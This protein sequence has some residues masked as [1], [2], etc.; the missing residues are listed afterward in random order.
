LDPNLKL[1]DMRYFL[2]ILLLVF[3]AC[4]APQMPLPGTTGKAGELVIVMDDTNWESE[5]GD[6][7]FNVLSQHV[8]GLPQPEPMFNVVHIKS[9]AF[10]SIFKTHR[11][12]VYATIGKGHA[13]SIQL[14]TNVWAAPQVVVEISAPTAK[15]FIEVFAANSSKILGHVLNKEES[16]I[17]KSYKAQLNTEVVKAVEVKFDLRMIIPKGYN[18]VREEDNFAWI[19]YETKDVTQSILVYSEPYTKENTFSAEGMTEVM[20]RFSKQYILGPD[21]TTYMSTYTEYP[22][23]L[24]ETSISEKYASKLTGLWH[25]ERAL[26]GGPF[27]SYAF[28]DPTEKTV[29]YVHGFV[30]APGKKKRNYLRQVDAILNSTR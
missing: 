29:F 19:R 28:L 2:P 30:F 7:V 21:E 13:K 20:N 18:L 23:R 5:A 9:S 14:K 11:N 1:A 12:V 10:T 24:E 26:M 3:T 6:T 4:E 27:V 17:L 15:E 8:Y 25:I 16:R 22:P